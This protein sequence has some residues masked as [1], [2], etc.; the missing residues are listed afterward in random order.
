MKENQ[1]AIMSIHISCYRYIV[2]RRTRKTYEKSRYHLY[3]IYP[4]QMC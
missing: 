1:E 2:F 3:P 4:V